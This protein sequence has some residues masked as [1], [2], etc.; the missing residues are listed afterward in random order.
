M[1]HVVNLLFELEKLELCRYRTKYQEELLSRYGRFKKNS[2]W[3][4]EES[5]RIALQARRLFS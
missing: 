3:G 2:S 4:T 5:R 1:S